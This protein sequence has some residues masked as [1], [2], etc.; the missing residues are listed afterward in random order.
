MYEVASE[1]HG[2]QVWM[3]STRSTCWSILERTVQSTSVRLDERVNMTE[4]GDETHKECNSVKES[5]MGPDHESN[6]IV[7]LFHGG[8][9]T[10]N[11]KKTGDNSMS[12]SNKAVLFWIKQAMPETRKAFRGKKLKKLT[13]WE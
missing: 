7:K 5:M 2:H 9:I 1:G 4:V 6:P 3:R 13:L 10:N 8:Y 12:A 11:W